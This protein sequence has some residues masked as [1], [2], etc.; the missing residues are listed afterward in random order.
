VAVD[1]IRLEPGTN[2][3]QPEA[4]ANG[5]ALTLPT[6]SRVSYYSR[7]SPNLYFEVDGVARTGG[8]GGRLQCAV[9]VESGQRTVVLDVT[10]EV[11]P[12]RVDVSGPVGEPFRFDLEVQRQSGKL[13]G[14]PILTLAGPR[15]TETRGEERQTMHGPP[16]DQSRISKR[17]N[18][19]IY[20]VDALRADRLGIYGQ[21]RPLSPNIDGFAARATV[22]DLAWAQSSWTR[23]A[24]A[25]IFTGLRPEVHGA[26]GRLDRLGSDMPTLAERF[27]EAGYVTAA[28]V[29]NP[30]V[31]AEFGFDRG[32]HS[33]GLIDPDKRRSSDVHAEVTAWLDAR[34]G[35][36]PFLLYIHTVD[37]HLPYD[38]PARFRELFAPSVVRD[39]LG[40]TEVVGALQA[41]S[42]PDEGLFAD[43]ILALYDAEVASN[44]AAF[45]MLLDELEG[46]RLANDTVVVF[47]SDHGEEFFDHGG[48]IHG[49]TLYREVMHVPLVIR[50]AGQR[51]G[52]RVEIAVQHVDLMPTLIDAAGLNPVP[53][54][55]GNSLL[56]KVPTDR[57]IAGFLDVDH[58]GGR[59]VV[60]GNWKAV[61]H[62]EMGFTGPVSVFDHRSDPAENRDVASERAVLGGTLVSESRRV[63]FGQEGRFAGG[64]AVIGDELRQRL[65]ALGYF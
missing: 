25:S 39:D 17:P 24:V 9:V 21:P 55:H 43:D 7:F 27:A 61:V 53:G 64:A 45:S 49:R 57:L 28:L 42:L 44:D 8:D 65:E 11:G 34:D 62:R 59:S 47:L 63:V 29:A 46:R 12:Q 51:E 15:L 26:N 4:A 3:P 33:Y 23:P 41:R 18:V 5:S 54:L 32:F 6:G 22:Y 13:D 19:V 10:G 14:G 50:Y 58:W 60:R 20:L 16:L 38:P 31:S 1:W 40:A 2:P 36:Q 52:R 35:G 30:N 37:P 56:R 48:W